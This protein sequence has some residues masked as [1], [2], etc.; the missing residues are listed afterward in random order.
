MATI[1]GLAH[2]LFGVAARN[3]VLGLFA[4]MGIGVVVLGVA[5]FRY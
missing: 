5:I 1:G 3:V 4:L 2:V